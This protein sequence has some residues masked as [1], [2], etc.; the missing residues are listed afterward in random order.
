[1]SKKP[2][3]SAKEVLIRLHNLCSS[4]LLDCLNEVKR[5]GNFLFSCSSSQP[6]RVGDLNSQ[7]A[8]LEKGGGR[9]SS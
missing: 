3:D 1:M 9:G 7:C 2:S 6:S 8:Q 5:R 4:R